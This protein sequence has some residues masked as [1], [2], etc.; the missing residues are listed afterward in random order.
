MKRQN[1]KHENTKIGKHEKGN[2]G[3]QNQEWSDAATVQGSRCTAN[4][5]T[6]DRD[7]SAPVQDRGGFGQE[8]VGRLP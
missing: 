6:A 1:N 7:G 2:E 8:G 3:G 4:S 5:K